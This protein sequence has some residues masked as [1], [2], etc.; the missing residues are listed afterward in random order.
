MVRQNADFQIAGCPLH[1]RLR[2]WWGCQ[3]PGAVD[4]CI[5]PVILL[6]LVGP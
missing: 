1:C 3:Q 2:L 6:D 5:F 4:L